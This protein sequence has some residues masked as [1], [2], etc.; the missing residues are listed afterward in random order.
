MPDENNGAPTPSTDT[1]PAA[2]TAPAAPVQP[3]PIHERG[4]DPVPPAPAPVVEPAP[5]SAASTISER[6]S[7]DSAAPERSQDAPYPVDPIPFDI[8][9]LRPDQLQALKAMLERT[10]LRAD[11]KRQNPLIRLRRHNNKVIIDIKSA[12]TAYIDDLVANTK[13]ETTLIPVKYVGEEEWVNIPYRDFIN[14]DQFTCEVVDIR[15]EE[16]GYD[17]GETWN[18][19]KKQMVVMR[20]TTLS[21]WFVI[22]FPDD[23][24]P[25]VPI[26]PNAEGRKRITIEA[27]MANA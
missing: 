4:P 1:P 26:E 9:A 27:R 18:E 10:P 8:N 22:E 19:E 23:I 16:G 21:E 2:P 20:V 5:G 15:R 7:R 17:E 6:L 24:A 13:H 25:M 3:E 12:F 11:K 14:A